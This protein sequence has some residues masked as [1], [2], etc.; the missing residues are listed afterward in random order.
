MGQRLD[1]Y[2][3]VPASGSIH[4][5]ARAV[6]AAVVDQDQ[7]IVGVLAVEIALDLL[8]GPRQPLLL[9]EARHDDA[10]HE[11]RSYLCALRNLLG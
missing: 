4:D 1:A 10:E 3:A 6:G 8:D 11:W 7:L 2:G 5:L 9:V